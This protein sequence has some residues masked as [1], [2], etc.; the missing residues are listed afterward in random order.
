MLLLGGI[1]ALVIVL[2]VVFVALRR[3]GPRAEEE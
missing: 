1:A 2:A 3:R